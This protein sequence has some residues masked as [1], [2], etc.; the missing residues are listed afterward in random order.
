MQRKMRVSQGKD[1]PSPALIY[2][3]PPFASDLNLLSDRHLCVEE[4]T[5][6]LWAKG[7][8]NEQKTFYLQNAKLPKQSV[9]RISWPIESVLNT[10]EVG[11]GG[12]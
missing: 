2:L 9:A 10:T 6:N 8:E 1:R 11:E 3:N 5:L 4:L 7:G 12:G